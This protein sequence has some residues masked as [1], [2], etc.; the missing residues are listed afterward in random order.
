MRELRSPKPARRRP[1]RRRGAWCGCEGDAATRYAAVRP[2]SS[3]PRRRGCRS[4]RW[5]AGTPRPLR[6]RHRRPVRWLLDRASSPSHPPSRHIHP[7]RRSLPARASRR[8]AFASLLHLC[9]LRRRSNLTLSQARGTAAAGPGAVGH[10]ALAVHDGRRHLSGRLRTSACSQ[11][12]ERDANAAAA[13]RCGAAGQRMRSSI[14]PKRTAGAMQASD[15][16]SGVLALCTERL[17]CGDD[18][19]RRRRVAIRTRRCSG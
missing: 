2:R 11:E 16:T 17:D 19:D 7:R 10:T 13:P 6:P 9:R 4:H 14:R 18:P 1:G 12:V 15:Q 3:G 8:H 5:F